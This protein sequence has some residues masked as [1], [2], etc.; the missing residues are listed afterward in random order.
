L[1]E[2]EKQKRR[3]RCLFFSLGEAV[4]RITI[5]CIVPRGHAKLSND[6]NGP[7]TTL[8]EHICEI[9]G[10]KL[11]QALFDHRNICANKISAKII[12]SD[13]KMSEIMCV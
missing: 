2:I 9:N 5:P 6:F 12:E 3:A 4:E 10:S 1:A 7:T 13:A 11:E 8:C